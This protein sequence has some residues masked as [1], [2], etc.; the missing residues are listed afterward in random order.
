MCEVI[1]SLFIKTCLKM[2]LTEQL[3]RLFLKVPSEGYH[4]DMSESELSFHE[5]EPMIIKQEKIYGCCSP[6]AEYETKTFMD[7][8]TKMGKYI[9]NLLYFVDCLNQLLESKFFVFINN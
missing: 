5:Q 7:L 2:N 9:L 3:L 8:S 6:S 4:S 1:S